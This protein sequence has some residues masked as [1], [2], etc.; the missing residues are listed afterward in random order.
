MKEMCRW[1]CLAGKQEER[2]AECDQR[3][4]LIGVVERNQ[5]TPY[6]KTPK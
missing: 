3:H 4:L 2:I 6:I 5:E 1:F